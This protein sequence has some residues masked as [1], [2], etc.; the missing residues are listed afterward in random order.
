VTRPAAALQAPPWLAPLLVF[1]A[2]LLVYGL[3]APAGLTWAHHSADGGDLITAARVQGVPHPTGYP[4]WTL[5]AALLGQLPLGTLAWRATLLSMLSA[6]AAA[7]LVSAAVPWLGPHNQSRGAEPGGAPSSTAGEPDA[8]RTSP[9]VLL[10]SLAPS[11][12]AGLALAFSPLLW[13]Q[14]TVA[15]VYALH[16]G[17]AA[18]ALWALVRWQSGG[19]SRWAAGA[20]LF[21]GLGL[22]NHL[23]TV[24]LLPAA[25]IVLWSGNGRTTSRLRAGAHLAAGLAAGLLVY[26]Y[27]PWAAAG[28]PPV[29][30]GNPS[31]LAGL[32]WLL[33]A[34]L[35]QDYVL[36]VPWSALPGRLAA[37][38]S[39]LWRNF[40]PWGVAAAIFG[41][42]VLFQRR[43]SLALALSTSLLLSLAWALSYNTSDSHLSLLPGWVILAM[44]GGVGVS[45]ALQGVAGWNRRAALAAAMLSIALAAAPAIMRWPAQNLRHD[46]AAEQFYSQVLQHVEPGALILTAGDRATFALWYG[47]Y[48]LGLRSDVALASRD[49]WSLASYRVTVASQHPDLAGP[50]LPDGTQMLPAEWQG[51]VREAGRQRPIY[52][53]QAG[54]AGPVEP[55]PVIEGYQATLALPGNGWALWQLAPIR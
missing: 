28:D 30:W 35:Y 32:W 16:A 41:L 54:L 19:S 4:T 43:R 20:G 9:A 47:R 42:V 50:S 48:G 40:L 1:C 8:G 13:G 46:Q 15:E 39:G 49:L 27:L 52:L 18:A 25:A 38:S 2:A 44:A 17:L 11:L 34:Q 51:L 53:A 7:A 6:A 45:A 12:A 26:L 3:T 37:G 5:L 14:A 23:T 33:S 21:L 31:T 10:L 22:G 36:A 55:S 24:W 29:N